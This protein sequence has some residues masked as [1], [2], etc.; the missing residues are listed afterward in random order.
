MNLESQ[1]ALLAQCPRIFKAVCD[2]L[3]EVGTAETTK[4][5]AGGELPKETPRGDNLAAPGTNIRTNEAMVTAGSSI[6]LKAKRVKPLVSCLSALITAREDGGRGSMEGMLSEVRGVRRAVEAAGESSE[7]LAVQNLCFQVAQEVGRW[8][9]AEAKM[10]NGGEMSGLVKGGDK[11]KKKKKQKDDDDGDRVDLS[12]PGAK[13]TEGEGSKSPAS[14]AGCFA[15]AAE[16]GGGDEDVGRDKDEK[17]ST[18][19]KKKKRKKNRERY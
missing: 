7:S 1:E 18:S 9:R 8:E 13:R 16:V 11:K 5:G 2:A 19:G 14:G 6:K 3:G 4:A 12:S 15:A 17:P 10:A